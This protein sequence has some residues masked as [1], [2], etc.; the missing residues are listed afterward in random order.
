M[1][2]DLIRALLI[3][4]PDV[5]SLHETGLQLGRV[6]ISGGL[7]LEGCR[8]GRDIGLVD[9]R[10]EY[11]PVLRSASRQNEPKRVPSTITTI[12]AISALTTAA[13]TIS[14]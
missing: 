1:R 14:R 10:F 6:W 7:D 9:C 5:P 13:M 4:G 11:Q 8:I 3:G 2:V 12:S